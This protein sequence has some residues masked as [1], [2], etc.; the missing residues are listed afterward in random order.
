MKKL[1]IAV[2]TGLLL[3]AGLAS[4]TAQDRDDTRRREIQERQDDAREAAAE[5][6]EEGALTPPDPYC[7]FFGPKHDKFVEA[8]QDR[9]V[10]SN[11]TEDVAGLLPPDGGLAAAAAAGMPSVPGGSR[12]DSAQNQGGIIDKYVFQKMAQVGVTPAPPTTDWEFVRR[13]TLDLTGRIPTPE[14]AI[15]FAGNLNSNKR[16]Q[17]VDDLLARPEW[18]DKWTI[19]FGDLYENNSTND[20]GAN[21]F[22]QGVV[23]FNDYIRA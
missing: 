6:V 9:F 2:S 20:L 12:T 19:W 10:L 8:L 22:I 13:V 21:R 7:T 14:A 11:L 16:A 3:A 1:L 18:V 15:A 17:L 23:K 5:V 4:I